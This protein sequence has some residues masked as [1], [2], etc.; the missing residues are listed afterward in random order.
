[1]HRSND[2]DFVR[3]GVE[4]VVRVC[5]VGNELGIQRLTAIMV[6]LLVR[7]ISKHSNAGSNPAQAIIYGL[8]GSMDTAVTQQRQAAAR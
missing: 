8:G 6:P 5:L 3:F 1:M 7:A 2:R 4:N